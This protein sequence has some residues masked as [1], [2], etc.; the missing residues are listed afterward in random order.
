MLNTTFSSV[1]S[2][3]DMLLITTEN[4][5]KETYMTRDHKT[6]LKSLVYICSNGKKLHSMDQNI[7]FSFML[8]TL[9]Y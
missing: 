2:I 4:V 3:C 9:G 7:N 5:L 6:S 1:D 8:E